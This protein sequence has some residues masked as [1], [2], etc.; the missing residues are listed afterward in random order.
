MRIEKYLSKAKED[1]LQ[2][3]KALDDK[4]HKKRSKYLVIKDYCNR[5]IW[6]P[7]TDLLTFSRRRYFDK[8]KKVYRYLLDEHL[9]LDK[10]KFISRKYQK[11]AILHVSVKRITNTKDALA[12]VDIF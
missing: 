5:T 8:K 12:M 11:L 1:L 3:W 7:Y 6:T 2:K 4:L 10:Y 9:A